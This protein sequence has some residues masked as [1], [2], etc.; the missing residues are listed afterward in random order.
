VIADEPTGNLDSETAG[1]VISLLAGLRRTAG[2]TLILA[3]HDDDIGR[4]AERRIRLRDG[5]IV[6]P[7]PPRSDGR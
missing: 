3:T 1:E 6:K 2:V 7:D 5:S 4:I